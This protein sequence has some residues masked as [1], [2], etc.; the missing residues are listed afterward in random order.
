[1][2]DKDDLKTFLK[3]KGIDITFKNSDIDIFFQR[4]GQRKQNVIM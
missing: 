4:Y 2:I 3:S 1:M